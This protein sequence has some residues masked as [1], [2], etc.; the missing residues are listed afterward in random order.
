MN[1]MKSINHTWPEAEAAAISGNRISSPNY[2]EGCFVFYQVP[3]EV[4][5]AII[6]K[7]SSL[8][9]AV[10][11]EFVRRGGPISYSHQYGFVFETNHIVGWLPSE[12]DKNASDWIIH[13]EDAPNNFT[14]APV[15]ETAGT[16]KPL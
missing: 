16:A 6:P 9:P 7:M 13:H 8:P 2:P 3:S 4:P 14:A 15:S 12:D 11:A 10:K 5:E 1:T